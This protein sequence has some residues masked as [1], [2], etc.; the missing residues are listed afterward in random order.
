MRF[1]QENTLSFAFLL[2][3]TPTNQMVFFTWQENITCPKV[4]PKGGPALAMHDGISALILLLWTT[5]SAIAMSLRVFYFIFN[6]NSSH[7]Q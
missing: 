7:V 5:F 4:G 2:T 1:N 3:I 6:I